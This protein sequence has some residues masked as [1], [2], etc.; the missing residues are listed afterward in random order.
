MNELK[1]TVATGDPSV[2]NNLA[3]IRKS[4][5]DTIDYVIELERRV[6]ILEEIVRILVAN[7]NIQ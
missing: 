5:N 2:G 3:S 1:K 7:S 6:S 4:A